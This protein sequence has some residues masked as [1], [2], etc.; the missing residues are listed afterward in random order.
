MLALA[1]VVLIGFLVGLV[2]GG[3]WRNLAG[4]K[5][6]LVSVIFVGVAF[7]VAAAL[8]SSVDHGRLSIALVVTSF[9]AVFA[10]A[11]ANWRLPGMALVALGAL[12]NLIVIWANQGMPVSRSALDRAGFT[13]AYVA[14]RGGARGAHHLLSDSSRLTPLA[15]VIPL[16]LFRNV[17]S[18]G[19]VVI[20]AGILLLV[21]DLTAGPR[22]RRKARA[23]RE[24]EEVPAGGPPLRPGA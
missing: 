14:G 23:L 18:A 24:A 2:R 6:R 5:F 21:Q 13:D 4:A 7:Q 9:A 22:G 3:S 16:P 10:F 19:D 8:L 12:S 15:D 1:V 11:A 17:V 20:W